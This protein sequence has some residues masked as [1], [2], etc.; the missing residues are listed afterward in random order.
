MF[1]V[2]EPKLRSPGDSRT[3]KLPFPVT[4]S[5]VTVY[6]MDGYSMDVKV[7]PIGE[8]YICMFQFFIDT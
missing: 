4:A 3:V 7:I 5:E 2:L 8:I 6:S 1:Q